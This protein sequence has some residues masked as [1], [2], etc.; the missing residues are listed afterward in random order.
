MSFHNQYISQFFYIYAGLPEGHVLE[1][2]RFIDWVKCKYYALK[3]DQEVPQATGL[4]VNGGH[5]KETL[6][7]RVEPDNS[8]NLNECRADDQ[9]FHSRG[10]IQARA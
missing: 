4:P 5:L 9:T 3:A 8:A 7:G 1:P 6:A 10:R 2:E